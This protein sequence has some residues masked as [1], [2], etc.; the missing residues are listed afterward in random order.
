MKIILSSLAVF[1]FIAIVGPFVAPFDSFDMDLTNVLRGPGV[2][3]IFGTDN[4][5]RD[6]FSR[7]LF[8]GRFSLGIGIISLV[9]S[10]LLGV[11]VGFV[12]GYAGGAIDRIL[13]IVI[14]TALSFP[15]LLLAIGIGVILPPGFWSVVIALSLSGWAGFARFTRGIVWEMKQNKYVESAKVL[16]SSH[17][18]I[19]GFHILPNS[20]PLIAVVG[21]M[22]LGTFILS[23]ASLSFLGFGVPPPY[24]TWGGMINY[25]REFIETAPWMVIFPGLILAFTVIL[26]NLA[27]DTL[28]DVLD[29]RHISEKM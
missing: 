4:Q 25:G 15:S 9:F 13:T 12:A 3:H 27:G 18:R 29:P 21:F 10:L 24:P 14:D 2:E 26:C 5:G 6:L 28:R 7:V 16:G 19:A 1:I 20:L 23:E 17:K 8:A 22:K 11:A